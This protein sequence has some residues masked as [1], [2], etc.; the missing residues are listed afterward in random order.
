MTTDT[1]P[2]FAALRL[3]I[4]GKTVHI[5]GIAKGAGMI[6]PNMATMLC[7]IGTDARI[8]RKAYNRRSATLLTEVSTA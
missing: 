1:K 4:N 8:G 2:K 5:G 6:A 3:E 7:F